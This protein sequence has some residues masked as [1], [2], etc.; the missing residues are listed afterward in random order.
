MATVR[1][2]ARQKLIGRACELHLIVDIQEVTE[3]TPPVDI[4]SRT[5]EQVTR[6][7]IDRVKTVLLLLPPIIVVDKAPGGD[8]R[9]QKGQVATE[10]GTSPE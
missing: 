8:L 4:D 7:V 10:T 1:S 6:R 3:D 9:A 5:Y 2:M